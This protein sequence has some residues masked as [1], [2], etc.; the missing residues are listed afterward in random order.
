M[1]ADM[2]FTTVS[3]LVA[4]LY[5][6]NLYAF[7]TNGNVFGAQ[8]AGKLE[9][10]PEPGTLLLLGTAAVGFV[11]RRRRQLAACALSSALPS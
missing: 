11:A 5:T 7:Q 3:N 9:S 2:G 10:V 1:Q 6:L 8:Y 4:G